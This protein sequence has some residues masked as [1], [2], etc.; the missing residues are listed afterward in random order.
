MQ[1]IE[2]ICKDIMTHNHL[3]IFTT[4]KL[5][6]T[7]RVEINPASIIIH[8]QDIKTMQ[9]KAD[10]MIVQRVANVKPQKALIVAD[11]TDAFV[12]LLPFVASFSVCPNDFT[13]HVHSMIDI[14]ATV[15]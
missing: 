8:C 6:I 7:V 13:I 12:L 14:N 11:D 9:E 15:S 2:L 1:L 3:L 4:K 5:T 10:T